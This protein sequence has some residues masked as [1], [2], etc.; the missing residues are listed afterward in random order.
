MIKPISTINKYLRRNLISSFIKNKLNA[1]FTPMLAAN[2]KI[3]TS[4]IPCGI[5]KTIKLKSFLMLPR[6][7]PIIRPLTTKTANVPNVK[8]KGPRNINNRATFKLFKRINLK[9]ALISVFNISLLEIGS[10]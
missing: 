4:I 5:N 10:V 2:I 6:A 3:G 9:S 7:L 1:I 8:V